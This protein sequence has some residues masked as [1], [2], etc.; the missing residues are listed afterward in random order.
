[1]QFFLCIFQENQTN[2]FSGDS[3]VDSGWERWPELFLYSHAPGQA[4]SWAGGEVWEW[5]ECGAGD[6]PHREKDDR[7]ERNHP[8]GP[9][10][11]SGKNTQGDNSAEIINDLFFTRPELSWSMSI[12]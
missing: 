9:G 7:T 4:D 2:H 11:H 3:E 6:R 1:M 10:G 12:N 8:T 5:R